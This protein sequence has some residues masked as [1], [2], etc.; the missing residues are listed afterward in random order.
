MTIKSLDELRKIREEHAG[1]VN[2]RERGDT[3]ED[4]IEILIGMATCG[5]SR[6]L[7]FRTYR[8]SKYFRPKAC[9]LWKRKEKHGSSDY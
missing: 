7:P 8:S 9:S 3:S 6:V 4:R 5:I 1:S 2:L